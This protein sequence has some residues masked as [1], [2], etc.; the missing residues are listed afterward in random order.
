MNFIAEEVREVLASL[1][2]K[3]LDEIVGRTELLEQDKSVVEN[4]GY[5]HEWIALLP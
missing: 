4:K 3:S 5:R 1:G 2:Y